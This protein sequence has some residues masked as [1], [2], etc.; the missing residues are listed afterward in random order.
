MIHVD[1]RLLSANGD[2][3]EIAIPRSE[4]LERQ[5][6]RLALGAAL[7]PPEALVGLAIREILALELLFRLRTGFACSLACGVDHGLRSVGWDELTVTVDRPRK[8]EQLR[9][10]LGRP[11]VEQPVDP[12]EPSPGDAGER[13]L[14]VRAQ[15]RSAFR[16]HLT[17]GL[18]RQ[19][20]E[21]NRLA[22]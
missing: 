17:H 16:D 5:E 20:P 2:G 22:A 4:L 7:G 6:E 9:P 13:R 11:R 15:A 8:F 21:G 10:P 1:R 12:V 19:S 18:L 14:L 3:D